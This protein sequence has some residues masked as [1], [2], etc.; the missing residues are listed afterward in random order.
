MICCLMIKGDKMKKKDELELELSNAGKERDKI[1]ELRDGFSR[2]AGVIGEDM[3]ERIRRIDQYLSSR[4]MAEK[5]K[6]EYA[7]KRLAELNRRIDFEYLLE[8]F[9]KRIDKQCEEADYKVR[10]LENR[11][12]KMSEEEE[13]NTTM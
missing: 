7:N 6:I 5:D 12:S 2:K 10:E 3:D 9:R 8:D 4:S 1:Y 13:E 11:F